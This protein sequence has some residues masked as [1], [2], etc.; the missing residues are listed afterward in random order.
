MTTLDIALARASVLEKID[1]LPLYDRDQYLKDVEKLT[2]AELK[3]I[4][5]DWRLYRRAFCWIIEKTPEGQVR[6]IRFHPKTWQMWYESNRTLNDIFLKLRKTGCSTDILKEMY[7][8]AA[9][10]GHQRQAM[11]SHEE[12]STKR[13]LEILKTT[14]SMNPVAPPLSRD[15]TQGIEF[16][17]THSRIWIGTAGARVFGRGDDLTMLHLSE[18][19]HFY[20]KVN[21][22]PNFMA[23]LSEAV[24]KGGRFIIESTPNGEDPI[25]WERWMASKN[26][27]LWNGIFLGVLDDKENADWAGDHPL[28]LASTRTNDFALSE[29]E[30]RLVLNRGA[31]LGNVRFLRYEKEKMLSKSILDPTSNAVMGD[32]KMLLQEYP[33]DDETCF[34]T[35]EDAV[36][37]SGMVAIY[38]TL[39]KSPLWVEESGTLKIWE[40]AIIGHAYVMF[41]DTSEGLPTSHW[42]TFAIYD[43]ERSRYVAELR[44]RTGMDELANI[45]ASFGYRYNNCL[46]MVERNNH[47]HVLLNILDERVH[48]PNLYYHTERGSALRR[49]EA[50]LGWPTR[51][52]DTKPLMIQT[53]KELFEAGAIEIFSLD[54]LHEISQYRYFDPRIAGPIGGTSKQGKYGPPSGGTDDLLDAYMGC[55]QGREYATSGVRAAVQHYGSAVGFGL[56]GAPEPRG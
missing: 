3:V 42:Q 22:A 24:A 41:V 1:A 6:P 28:A 30:Q 16:E 32:E 29:Y 50:R 34:L 51:A 13:L 15:N 9:T 45:V 54:A 33:V 23:G 35:S 17:Y 12:D 11:M 7:A 27:E 53:F 8:K 25:F 20:K 14:H 39:T 18:A 56:M 37:D 52:A 2:K 47:G 55:L 26:G 40:K 36:F 43:V 38:R 49:G 46:I 10:L 5:S 4:Y 44:T 48:Y 19:A 21:D 31:S